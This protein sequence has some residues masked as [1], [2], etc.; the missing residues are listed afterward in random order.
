MNC[1]CFHDSLDLALKGWYLHYS[2]AINL[3]STVILNVV[4]S[5]L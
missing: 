2:D 4:L 1:L 3:L 5:A